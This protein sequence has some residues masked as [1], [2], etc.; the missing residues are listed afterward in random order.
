[1]RI[2]IPGRAAAE[3]G[4]AAHRQ[5]FVVFGIDTRCCMRVSLTAKISSEARQ[6]P[7]KEG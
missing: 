2:H 3:A 5:R 7:I 4:H 1:V 6:I